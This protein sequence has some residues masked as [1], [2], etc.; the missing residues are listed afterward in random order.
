MKDAIMPNLMQ[1]L[2]ATGDAVETVMVPSVT[3]SEKPGAR[4]PVKT[5]A[6]AD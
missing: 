4:L 3:V 6:P 1:T 2:E 5:S